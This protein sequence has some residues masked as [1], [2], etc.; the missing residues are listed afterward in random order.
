MSLIDAAWR[1]GEQAWRDGLPLDML[2]LVAGE[3]G[4]SYARGGT[5]RICVRQMFDGMGL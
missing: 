4:R 1:A 3:C 5:P 2:Y